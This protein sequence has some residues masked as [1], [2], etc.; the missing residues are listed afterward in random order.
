ME[1][2]NYLESLRNMKAAKIAVK[3]TA[4]HVA[5]AKRRSLSPDVII[6]SDNLRTISTQTDVGTWLDKNTMV[7][8]K[9]KRKHNHSS[10]VIKNVNDIKGTVLVHGKNLISDGS[11]GYLMRV[12]LN[13]IRPLTSQSRSHKN[14]PNVT[15]GGY[16]RGR[17]VGHSP[18]HSLSHNPSGY[19][20]N[21][22]LPQGS[23]GKFYLND[24]WYPNEYRSDRRR[25]DNRPYSQHNTR[26]YEDE[27]D[28]FH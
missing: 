20:L 28:L 17:S 16:S 15:S 1:R 10:E 13:D 23:S 21:Q 4:E 9:N 14:P 6:F 22:P 25:S 5:V 19:Y 8:R 2:E 7:N 24:S 3:R 27:S 26:Y 18:G 12:E 11:G